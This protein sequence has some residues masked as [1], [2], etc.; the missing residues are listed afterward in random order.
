M[1][2][3][4]AHAPHPLSLFLPAFSCTQNNPLNSVSEIISKNSEK[5]LVRMRMPG[6]EPHQLN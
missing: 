6:I 3:S 2:H 5:F 4:G 1:G